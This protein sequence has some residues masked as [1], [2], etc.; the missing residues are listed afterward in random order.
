MQNIVFKALRAKGY[1]TRLKDSIVQ[2]YDKEMSIAE[3]GK[4][5]MPGPDVYD[6]QSRWWKMNQ[7]TPENLRAMYEKM[8]R[9]ANKIEDEMDQL[10]ADLRYYKTV[11]QTPQ[12]AMAVKL[13]KKELNNLKVD[14]Q[15][16]RNDRN[17][18]KAELD[19]RL[20]TSSQIDEGYGAG[21]P[22]TDRLKIKNTDG[23]VK[24]WQIRSKDAPSTP[25]MKEDVD[26]SLQ[27]SN[28]KNSLVAW[29]KAISQQ[30]VIKNRVDLF[31]ETQLPPEYNAAL[32]IGEVS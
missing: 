6:K 9:W 27:K 19:K 29:M 14:L 26:P 21:I 18:Y 10:L 1:L 28:P 12:V 16:M 8:R 7:L 17:I 13:R 24:R 31:P 25:K 30:L 15:Q 4:Q 32:K 22:E 5:K 11:P 2:V 3:A 20:A 23:S